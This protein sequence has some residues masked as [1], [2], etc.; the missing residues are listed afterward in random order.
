MRFVTSYSMGVSA[1]SHVEYLSIP[2]L[3]DSYATARLH[4][5]LL[6]PRCYCKFAPDR[7]VEAFL[8]AVKSRG[9]LWMIKTVAGFLLDT[10]EATEDKG[11][12]V[13]DATPGT[14]HTL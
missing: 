6:I 14:I 7:E 12:A 3:W 10:I 4:N 8:E 13:Y 11:R 5:Y 9:H 1:S 2:F